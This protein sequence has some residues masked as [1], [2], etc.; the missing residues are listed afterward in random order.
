MTEHNFKIMQLRLSNVLP[1]CSATI[2]LY[3]HKLQFV[4]MVAALKIP[5]YQQTF[6]CMIN[7]DSN[8]L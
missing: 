8:I 5:I 6:T 7:I 3:I 4:R 2:K 1:D